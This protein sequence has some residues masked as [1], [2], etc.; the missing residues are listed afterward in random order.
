MCSSDLP[1]KVVKVPYH[2]VCLAHGKPEPSPRKTYRLIKVEQFTKDPYLQ[3]LIEMVG[4]NR[5]NHQIAQAAAWNLTDKMSWRKLAA[6]QQKQLG[7]RRPTPYFTRAQIFYA[8]QLVAFAVGKVKEKQEK[9]SKG[10]STE[11]SSGRKSVSRRRI[12]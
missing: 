4:T 2:S 9:E 10:E 5:I 8:Q 11:S 1:E 12:R 3:M 7:G 6:K